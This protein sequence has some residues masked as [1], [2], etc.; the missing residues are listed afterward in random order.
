MIANYKEI[1]YLQ[2]RNSFLGFQKFNSK[3]NYDNMNLLNEYYEHENTEKEEITALFNLILQHQ[4][5][6]I[7]TAPFKTT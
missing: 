1:E 4:K 3:I 2:K 6:F 7:F 5:N